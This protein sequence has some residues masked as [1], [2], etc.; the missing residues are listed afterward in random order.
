MLTY[1]GESKFSELID[2]QAFKEFLTVLG[3]IYGITLNCASIPFSFLSIRNTTPFC[4]YLRENPEAKAICQ[5]YY[6]NV[7]KE[8]IA[9]K[10]NYISTCPFGLCH[11][12]QPVVSNKEI[13][14]G[15]LTGPVV[16]HEWTKGDV[17]K[18]LSL[19]SHIAVKLKTKKES[20]FTAAEEEFIGRFKEISSVVQALLSAISQQAPGKELLAIY[21]IF[22]ILA[23]CQNQTQVFHILLSSL[24]LLYSF[25]A[26]WIMLK[27][28][29]SPPKL[30]YGLGYYFNPEFAEKMI[31]PASLEQKLLNQIEPLIWYEGHLPVKDLPL[32]KLQVKLNTLS[33]IPFVLR[34]KAMGYAVLVNGKNITTYIISALFGFT[35]IILEN[36]RIYQHLQEMSLTDE[37]TGLYNHRYFGQRMEEELKRA[38]RYQSDFA[39]LIIDLDHLK[40]INDQYGFAIGDEVLKGIAKVL[41]ETV[42][43]SDTIARYSDDEFAVILQNTRMEDAVIVAGRIKNS[44]LQP[45]KVPHLSEAIQLTASIG[46]AFYP[47]DGNNVKDIIHKAMQRLYKA[48]KDGCNQICYQ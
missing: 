6:Q 37:L 15:F 18:D 35:A 3:E 7:S 1:H 45:I 46:M 11:M 47:E 17:P 33:Y 21:H 19:S 22:R 43:G 31:L 40:E 23:A 24:N 5:E 27:E 30:A 2:L 42:R 48:K 28:D 36:V 20:L 29:H 8:I 44:L 26:S 13:V 4:K 10:N 12:I 32:D 9:R 34:N 25:D 39:C 16:L 38:Q 14:G 41:K